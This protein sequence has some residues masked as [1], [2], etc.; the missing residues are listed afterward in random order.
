MRWRER[1]AKGNTGGG[2]ALV[3]LIVHIVCCQRE[4]DWEEERSAEDA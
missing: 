3:R 1:E 4:V 2:P